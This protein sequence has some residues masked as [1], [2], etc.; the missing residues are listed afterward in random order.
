MDHFGPECDLKYGCFINIKK[1]CISLG[2][3][4]RNIMHTKSV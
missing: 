2:S 1:E 4:P 3:L